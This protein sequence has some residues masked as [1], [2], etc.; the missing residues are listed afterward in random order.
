MQALMVEQGHP[1]QRRQFHRF[2][3]LPW[4]PFVDQ[5][6]LVQP[7]DR[8]GQSVVV[9]VTPATHRR[10]HSSF[11]KPLGIADGDILRAP[12]G[13]VDQTPQFRLA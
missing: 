9:A 4:P 5:F 13:M 6:S 8:L 7:V 10:F 1:F 3:V 2:P 11:A 12:V